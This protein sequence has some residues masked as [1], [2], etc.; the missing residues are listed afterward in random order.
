MA[1]THCAHCGGTDT[2]VLLG[3]SVSCLDC[4]GRTEAGVAQPSKPTKG[5]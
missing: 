1:V 2:L 3:D 4:G 5:K